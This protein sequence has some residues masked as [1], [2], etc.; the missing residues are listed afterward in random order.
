M[1]NQPPFIPPAKKAA[2]VKSTQEQ[3]RKA[4]EQDPQPQTDAPETENPVSEKTVEVNDKQVPAEQ[5]AFP[6]LH[7]E[8]EVEIAKRTSDRQSGEDTRFRKR[9]LVQKEA[10]VLSDE[11]THPRN[12]VSVVEQA[13]QQGLHPQG[14]PTFDGTEDHPSGQSVYLD[15][16]VEV[17]PAAVDDNPNDAMSP[18]KLLTEEMDGSTDTKKAADL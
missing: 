10:N 13:I 18:W 3:P 15:Y 1:T 7:G 5:L 14:V 6:S 9:F 12:F 11:S 16:S 2:P 8:P 17:I 4:A